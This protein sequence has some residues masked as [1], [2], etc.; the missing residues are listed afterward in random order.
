MV[1]E[2]CQKLYDIHSKLYKLHWTVIN[3][4]TLLPRTQ[5]L[6][7]EAV[8]EPPVMN[9]DGDR[10]WHGSMPNQG[11]MLKSWVKH[12][13]PYIFNSG[14]MVIIVHSIEPYRKRGRSDE[15]E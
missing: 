2:E 15:D 12:K 1:Q 4:N 11:M 5:T 3:P 7:V 8:D 9:E 13:M 6:L 14:V 10:L